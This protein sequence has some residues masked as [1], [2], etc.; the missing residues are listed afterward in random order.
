MRDLYQQRLAASPQL[1]KPTKLSA[2]SESIKSDDLG[3]IGLIDETSVAKKGDET[4]GV[5]RQYCGT[6]GK[7]EN[8][9]VTVHLGVCRGGFK[10]LLDSDLFL[11]ESWSHDRERCRAADIPDSVV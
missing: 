7:Q 3:M 8:G 4:P 10:T 2:L 1:A 6:L 9:I 5:Q 11:P